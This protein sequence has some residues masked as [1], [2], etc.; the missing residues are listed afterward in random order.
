MAFDGTGAQSADGG[1]VVIDGHA[2]PEKEG[3]EVSIPLNRLF[4]SVQ[5]VRKVRNPQTIPELA[6]TINEQGLL[7][8][9]SVI[10]EKFKGVKG[11]KGET[12]GV[13]A[14]GRRLAALQHLV[15]QGLMKADEPV[16]CL[17]FPVNRAVAVSLTENTQQEAMHPADQLSAFKTMMDEGKDA[18][19]IAAAFG[20]SVLTVERRLKLANL[21][22]V[23]IELFREGKI[24]QDQMQALATVTDHAL[25][26]KVWE[27]QPSY[28]RSAY[29]L[30][31]LLTADETPLSNDVASF[32]GLEAYTAAGGTVRKDLF[33]EDDDT[34][35]QDGVLLNDLAVTKL[36]AHAQELRALGWKWV[37]VSPELDRSALSRFGRMYAEHSEPTEEQ[38]AAMEAV[39][40]QKQQLR[41]RQ[42]ELEGLCNGDDA[43]ELTEAED[44]ELSSLEEQWD[45][46]D[47]M[48]GG[49]RE[50]LRAW[51]PE[52]RAASGVIVSVGS[53]G[54]EITAGLVRAEDRKE[55]DASARE[56]GT[57]APSLSNAPKERAAYSAV[58]CENLTAHRS[59]AVAASLA[60]SPTVALA[61]LVHGL[62]MANREAWH[63]SP[64]S[65]RLQSHEGPNATA[66]TGFEDTQ[67]AKD[68]DEA[69]QVF[70]HLPGDSERLFFHLQAMTVPDLLEVLALLVGYSYSVRT[71]DMAR[72][73]YRGF[74]PARG[75]E[76]AL[77]LDM[78]DWW[79]P[80]PERFLSHVSKGVAMEAVTEACGAEAA[81]PLEKMKKGE[82]VAAAAALLEGKRWLPSTLRPYAA[83]A[84]IEL[85]ADDE[86]GEG[87]E[88]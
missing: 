28:H 43:R 71:K 59:S 38:H 29:Y 26:I 33:A 65:F 24:G 21:A 78:A 6:A 12:F 58:L 83:P 42:Y 14:G 52:Q 8:R 49:M 37:E 46:L 84:A 87:D 35:L 51:T 62:V 57:A 64:F 45:N 61:A 16:K 11:V 47:D 73:Y 36:E 50:A 80:T 9:L 27:G 76:K 2:V 54:L 44:D 30:R 66:M 75:V 77:D 31:N 74:D 86:E 18:A 63:E 79:T 69:A 60:Q 48:L 17:Q 39:T 72:A 19:Q 23:F 25:Q 85:E 68:L 56:S 10:P 13:I 22:P 55:M 1:L 41:E 7:A 4:L 32:V 3:V 70:E 15:G 5:N 88:D 34:Y 81:K 40:L 82:A 20:V 53:R 67:A